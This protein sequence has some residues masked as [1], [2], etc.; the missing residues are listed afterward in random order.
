MSCKLPQSRAG[1]VEH[2]VCF[3]GHFFSI[4]LSYGGEKRRLQCATGMSSSH[5]AARWSQAASLVLWRAVCLAF[6]RHC[7]LKQDQL[8]GWKTLPVFHLVDSGFKPISTCG[9]KSLEN[10]NEEQRWLLIGCLCCSVVLNVTRR[11]SDYLGGA[12][13]LAERDGCCVACGSCSSVG[14]ETQLHLNTFH[15]R[16]ACWGRYRIYK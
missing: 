5:P 8:C 9:I 7:F 6:G 16:T 15:M 4:F 3:I 14:V 1:C 10:G 11:S 13:H 2:S 12:L